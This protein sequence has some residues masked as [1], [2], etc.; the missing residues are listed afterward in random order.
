MPNENIRSLIARLEAAQ[1][2]DAETKAEVA[3]AIKTMSALR[4]AGRQKIPEMV[5][6]T[7]D[8]ILYLIDELL[9]DW[10]IKLKGRTNNV[11]G[12]WVCIL[13]KSEGR[14]NDEV[15]GI[16]RSAALPNALLAA[17]LKLL[18]TGQ[19]SL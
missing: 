18:A 4:P 11:S 12:H 3:A 9:P 10:S 17:M 1:A 7:T 2:L 16:G 19:P 8:Q 14:D 13:R 15:I 6:L 5:E